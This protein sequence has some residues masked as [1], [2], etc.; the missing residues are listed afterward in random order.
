MA[1]A[2]SER[3]ANRGMEAVAERPDGTR[4]PFIPYPTPL[5]DD[6]GVLIG[7]VN[8]LVD[9][10]DRKRGEEAVQRL[11]AIVESSDDAI[12]TKSLDGT[13]TT[14]NKG[15]ERMFGYTAAEIIGK[16][17]LTLIPED[18]H[19]EEPSILSRIRDGARIDHIEIGYRLF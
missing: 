15:A 18:L 16:S 14:W 12:M 19:S 13:I 7:A 11:A 8:M 4:V 6:D 5:F 10:T 3:L 17:V 1:I 2:I 9:I